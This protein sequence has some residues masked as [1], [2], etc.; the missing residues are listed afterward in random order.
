MESF[1][2]IQLVQNILFYFFFKNT[3]Y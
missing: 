1:L 2:H 3:S